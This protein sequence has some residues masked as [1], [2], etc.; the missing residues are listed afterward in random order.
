[1]IATFTDL[2][3]RKSFGYTGTEIA[4]PLERH[5]MYPEFY[6]PDHVVLM[7]TPYNDANELN[8]LETVLCGLP[9]ARLRLHGGH[10]FL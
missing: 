2:V 1:M 3:L 10:C 5:G 8:R 6:D 9:R 4:G 7:L